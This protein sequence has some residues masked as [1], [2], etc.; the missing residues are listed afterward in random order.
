MKK[1]IF[2]SLLA[3]FV[4]GNYVAVVNSY[5]PDCDP[6]GMG[7]GLRRIGL[8]L[9]DIG[10][11]LAGGHGRTWEQVVSDRAAMCLNRSRTMSRSAANH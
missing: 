10:R 9:S 6:N 11:T 8:S 7:V 1:V 2:A 5:G 3:L 4:Y